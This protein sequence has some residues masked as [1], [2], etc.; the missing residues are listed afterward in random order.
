MKCK[1]WECR[2]FLQCL[3]V[4]YFLL[5]LL[6]PIQEVDLCYN[7]THTSNDEGILSTACASQPAASSASSVSSPASPA[8]SSSAPSSTSAPSSSS[9]SSASLSASPA[10]ST[11]ASSSWCYQL[12]IVCTRFIMYSFTM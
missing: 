11:S 4:F 5:L 3:V 1:W 6:V 2:H 8:S 9:A 12:E 7:Y 10:A